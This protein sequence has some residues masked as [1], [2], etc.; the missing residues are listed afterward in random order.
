VGGALSLNDETP[1]VMARPVTGDS[2]AVPGV[3]EPA[4]SAD[5]E[6]AWWRF[7]VEYTVASARAFD[8]TDYLL[9]GFIAE[10]E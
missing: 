1:V 8:E 3:G 2:E 4:A 10:P 7:G 6:A 5:R 9:D